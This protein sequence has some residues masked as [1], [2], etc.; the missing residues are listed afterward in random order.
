MPFDRTPE[1]AATLN[2][3][4]AADISQREADAG[5][6]L[7]P[8]VG[9]QRQV[10]NA[11]VA[12]MLAMRQE[13]DKEEATARHDLTRRADD[14][15]EMQANHDVAMRAGADEEEVQANHDVAMR[16]ETDEE[17]AQAQT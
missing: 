6:A 10:G 7:H 8:L 12:R 1:R 14:E 5:R 4:L 15:E 16:A 9:L 2:R 3:R 11:Q 17:E 13:E